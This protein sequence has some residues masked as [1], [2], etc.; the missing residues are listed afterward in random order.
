MRA[1]RIAHFCKG[2]CSA[3]PIELMPIITLQIVLA[4]I[5][6]LL[7][8]TTTLQ[9]ITAQ[10][11]CTLFYTLTSQLIL[12]RYSSTSQCLSLSLPTRQGLPQLLLRRFAALSS[13]LIQYQCLVLV[14]LVRS[15]Q[16]V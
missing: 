14:T 16:K 8:L 15:S 11:A 1:A 5:P 7:P 10:I 9:A 2:A 12:V 13:L 3:R 6:K 4:T